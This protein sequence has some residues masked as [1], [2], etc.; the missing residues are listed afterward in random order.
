MK[1][2]KNDDMKKFQASAPEILIWDGQLEWQKPR[3]EVR[4]FHN[5]RVEGWSGYVKT[6]KIKGWV[7]NVRIALFVEKWKRDNGGKSPTNDEILEWMVND[8]HDEF[9][10][11]KL[12]ENIVKNGVRQQI[13]IESDG[14][15]L[16]GNRRYFAS[17]HKLRI[18]EK[19]ED[20]IAKQ[21]VSQ[22][23]AFVMSPASSPA[24]L[25]AVLV[26]ENFVDD[27]RREWPNF[28]KAQ[29]VF[30]TYKDLKENGYSRVAAI[31]HLTE[32]FGKKKPEIDRWIRMM[33]NIAEFHDFHISDD[34]E[35]GREA[36]DE[37]DVMWRSQ[38]R[39]E[40]FDELTKPEVVR[41]LDADYE[42]RDKV[43][44]RLYAEDFRNFTQIRKI[45][46]ISKDLR[47]RDK[48]MLL[49]GREAV[50]EAI[51]WVT[52]TGVAKRSMDLQDRIVAFERFL[53][54]LTANDI[55]SLDRLSIDA[56]RNISA[57]VAEMAEA[58]TG[59]TQ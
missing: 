7:D 51:R 4:Y 27:C 22:L 18:L 10:L 33:N 12:A 53:G 8:P 56:L 16:D 30:E 15:L 47:A 13:I 3:Q 37:Y 25:D 31:D 11:Q 24:D 5:R 2:K 39:F 29:R 55:D 45:P 46:A 21:M 44:D 42:L 40:Y 36:K 41:T 17:L 50:D 20:E 38:E 14:T 26:E 28:I 59:E 35:S 32:R 58:I 19:S 48:F 1:D 54:S 52:I 49:N 43:F 23:P 6:D 9:A 34:E 57:K